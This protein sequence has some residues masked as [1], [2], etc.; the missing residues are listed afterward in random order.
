MM[1]GGNLGT[2]GLTSPLK[3]TAED[4]VNHQALV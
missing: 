4:I 3:N 1:N 2:A